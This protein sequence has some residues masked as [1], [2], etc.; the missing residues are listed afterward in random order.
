MAAD[1]AKPSHLRRSPT[2]RQPGPASAD[3]TPARLADLDG[4][5][6]AAVAAV[7]AFHLAA[8]GD[9]SRRG[10][11]AG[12]WLGVDTFFVLSGYLITSLLLGEAERSGGI[13]LRGFWRR[14][15][16]RLQ[17]GALLAIA[18]A[19][20]TAHWWA[21]GGTAHAVRGEALAALS[22]TAN[23]QSLWAHHPYAAGVAPS[24][25]EHFWSLAI[26]EQ[27]YFVW[28]LVLAAVAAVVHRRRRRPARARL[29]VVVVALSGVVASWGRLASAP[30]QRGYL[31][32]DT[33]AGSILLGAVLAALLPLE[34]SAA[35]SL[36]TRRVAAAGG[37]ACVLA[38][39]C[40]WALAGWPPRTPLVVFL[41]ANASLTCGIIAAAR[42]HP[43]GVVSRALGS[44]PLAGLGR[45]SYGVY[46][47]HWPLFVLLTPTRLGV[48][49]GPTNVVR[50]VTLAGVVR[51]TGRLVEVP[52]RSGRLLR[53]TRTGLPLA[54]LGTG[55]VIVVGLAQ[56][57]PAPAWASARGVLIRSTTPV[58]PATLTSRPTIAPA[59]RLVWPAA[60]AWPG[61]LGLTGALATSGLPG[62][63][64]TGAGP[65]P[66]GGSP[67]P[68]PAQDTGPPTAGPVR[69]LVVGDSLPTSL[70]EG[71]DAARS[72]QPG[73]GH[74][75]S[76]FAQAG[77]DAASMTISGCPV[78]DEA[79]V[80]LGE[81]RR[82]CQTELRQLL[83]RAMASVRPT[84][85]V[86]YSTAESNPALLPDGTLSDPLASPADAALLR[87]RYEERV[88]WFAGLGAR[89]ILVSP[90]PN[91]DGHDAKDG[92]GSSFRSMTFL[93]DQLHLV[94]D[95]DPA[96]VVGVV[97]M[98]DLVCP[99]WRVLRRCA[100]TMAGGGTF[101]PGDGQHFGAAGALA[102]GTWLVAQ[103]AA[104]VAD[105]A[106]AAPAGG[107]GPD[108]ATGRP[109]R[110]PGG[111][112]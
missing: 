95:A 107:P 98:G 39:G 106:G 32:T 57:D 85:V 83:P 58:P 38:A 43:G 110:W 93:D 5:R 90:G 11:L 91:A 17:P 94:A 3:G 10:L 25:F 61:L 109:S 13:D 77:I 104:D 63:V 111:P 78:V 75:L 33:R 42:L 103:V 28:P 55:A 80:E 21:P 72:L 22:A 16:R 2:R 36:T 59:G 112:S 87:Q 30:L 92:H 100:D 46:L 73:Q 34:R 84:I 68:G 74:L 41:A 47:W 18:F 102:A 105:L 31:G 76:Q 1:A 15:L 67:A 69:V 52:V 29:T 79:V 60:L 89:V 81:T 88:R 27:F 86:W 65:G 8:L 51:V 101:R 54:W 12:G 49:L 66:S 6:G 9:G 56:V 62:L 35:P 99:G 97:G 70:L 23:W 108:A 82:Y 20:A 71:Q 45:V 53:R 50:L 26:E 24:A 44:G 96:D 40:L 64:G 14:R 19:V 4:L 7:V 48:G 37:G